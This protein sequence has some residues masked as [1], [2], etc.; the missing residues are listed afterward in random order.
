[1]NQIYLMDFVFSFMVG[2]L[3]FVRFWIIYLFLESGS[4][5]LSNLNFKLIEFWCGAL[6]IL[7]LV[8]QVVFSYGCLYYDNLVTESLEGRSLSV[9]VLGRQ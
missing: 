5:K 9:K 2:I 8:F 6:P 7:I 4:V 3:V 1:M